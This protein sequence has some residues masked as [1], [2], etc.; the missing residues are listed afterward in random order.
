LE[1][2]NKEN[3][4]GIHGSPRRSRIYKPGELVPVSGIYDIVDKNGNS[5]GL[6]RIDVKGK[7]FPAGSRGG[8]FKLY[9]P[10]QP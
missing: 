9:H 6:Q 10:P 3:A 2:A 1:A 5:T 7:I 4:M 8:G